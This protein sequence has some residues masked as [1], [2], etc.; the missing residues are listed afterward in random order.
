MNL[1]LSY[2]S[3]LR[4]MNEAG[5]SHDSKVLEW[6][7][8]ITPKLQLRE[9]CTGIVFL[10]STETDLTNVFVVLFVPPESCRSVDRRRGSFYAY[11]Q[12]SYTCTSHQK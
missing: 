10:N 4:L 5:E 11:K 12:H 7:Q 1:T 6:K 3:V 2:S 9:V 8:E